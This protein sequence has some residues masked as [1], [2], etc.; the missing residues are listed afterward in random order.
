MV[1]QSLRLGDLVDALA[2]T[3]A[4][5]R[6]V[7]LDSSYDHRFGRGTAQPV[8]P[9]LAAVEA[10][11]GMT[12][13]SAAAPGEIAAEAS[14]TYSLYPRTLVNLMRQRGLELDKVFKG[15]RYQVNQET[16][17]KQTPW[18]STALMT[19]V[20]LFPVTATAPVS[21]PSQVAAPPAKAE[22]TKKRSNVARSRAGNVNERQADPHKRG[23]RVDKRRDCLRQRLASAVAG[24]PSGLANNIGAV[25]S[26]RRARDVPGA[27]ARSL[28]R[29]LFLLNCHSAGGLAVSLDQKR[30]GGWAPDLTCIPCWQAYDATVGSR[31]FLR[32]SRFIDRFS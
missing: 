1:P 22:P 10:P 7:V 20:T 14:G 5:A 9:G 19:D 30:A 8:L 25:H 23:R 4:A 21:P 31:T 24:S 27:S 16:A 17:G 32:L 18:I 12:I 28:R 3:S 6:I 13:A 15:A 26:D 29:S 2:Q 11:S